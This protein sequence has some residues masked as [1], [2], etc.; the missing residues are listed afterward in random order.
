MASEEVFMAATGIEVVEDIEAL[1]AIEASLAD[2]M[3]VGIWASKAIETRM[4]LKG[5][6]TEGMEKEVSAVEVA[7]SREK[8]ASTIAEGVVRRVKVAFTIMEVARKVKGA[9]TTTMVD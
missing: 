7:E 2:S 8:E 6:G 3:E 5:V 1:E 4:D 9:S